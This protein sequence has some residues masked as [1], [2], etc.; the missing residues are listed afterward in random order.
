[1]KTNLLATVGVL[2]CGLLFSMQEASASVAG[3]LYLDGGGVTV[4]PTNLVWNGDATVNSITTLP[5]G[6]GI[7]VPG[8]TDVVLANLPG[9]LPT[10]I[11]DFMTFVGIPSL[12]FI[13]DVA[14]PGSSNTN[15]SAAGLM[16]NSGECSAFAGSPLILTQGTNGTVVS[17]GVSGTVTDGSSPTSLW[18]GEFAETITTLGSITDPTPLQIQQFFGGPSTPNSNTLSSTYSGTFVASIQSSVPEPS[19]LM[20]MLTGCGLILVALGA[21]RK[22]SR[23]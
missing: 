13:L 16:A 14:G 21:R 3:S 10:P 9:S 6:L 19:T 22:A 17:L 5:Y 20:M 12:D 11:N 4:S 18:S 7:L 2:C 8:G 23:P 1:M 15:C